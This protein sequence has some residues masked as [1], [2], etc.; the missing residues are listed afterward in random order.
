MNKLIQKHQE[1]L[2]VCDD[3]LCDY[4][5]PYSEQEDQKLEEY[6]NTPCPSCG[7]NLLTEEDYKLAVKLDKIIDRINKW[8]GWIT[9]FMRKN[10]DTTV[11]KSK[12]IGIKVHEGIKITKEC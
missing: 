3:L 1:N 2:I 9:I 6:I 8:F 5:V 10:K 12:T 7:A 4:T 11:V